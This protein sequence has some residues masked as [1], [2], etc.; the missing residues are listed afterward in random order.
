MTSVTIPRGSL[1]LSGFLFK[2]S[3]TSSKT[4]ALVIVHPGGGVKEQTASLY[5]QKLAN[6]AF[7]IICYD[8]S[9]QSVSGGELHFLENP[10]VRV[11]DVWNVI[12]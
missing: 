2:P 8:A 9:H 6:N 3:N 10:N 5:A 7:T 1:Q 4:P 11:S 12:N